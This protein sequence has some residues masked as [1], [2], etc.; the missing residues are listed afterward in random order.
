MRNWRGLKLPSAE[1]LRSAAFSIR[2]S[3]RA[4][5]GPWPL[6]D[7]ELGHPCWTDHG[8]A[9]NF[10][11]AYGI[12]WPLAGLVRT[13]RSPGIRSSAQSRLEALAAA[14]VFKKGQIP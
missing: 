10:M 11:T 7:L 3:A 6:R 12:S 14:S 5:H 13:L 2:S 8:H 4:G 9:E 1:G